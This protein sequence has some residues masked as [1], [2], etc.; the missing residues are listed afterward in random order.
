MSEERPDDKS[1]SAKISRKIP[2]LD[3][4]E[5]SGK[6][7]KILLVNVCRKQLPVNPAEA[8]AWFQCERNGGENGEGPGTSWVKNNDDVFQN[9]ASGLSKSHGLKPRDRL[10]GISE[11]SHGFEHSNE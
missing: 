5:I 1:P 2:S 7:D 11:V 9:M 8:L 10:Y 4:E 3:H 6:T